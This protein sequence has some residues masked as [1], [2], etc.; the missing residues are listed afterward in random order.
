M[1]KH[2]K[3]SKKHHRKRS[4][5][6]S[7]SILKT[8]K[9]FSAP[10][11]PTI[12]NCFFFSLKRPRSPRRRSTRRRSGRSPS[13]PLSARLAESLVSVLLLSGVVRTAALTLCLSVKLERSYKKSKKH[14]KKAKRR[15]H[16]SVRTLC[17]S[18]SPRCVWSVP[19]LILTTTN[20]PR[21]TLTS[22]RRDESATGSTRGRRR[23]IKR[24]TSLGGSPAPSP[25]WS[26]LKRKQPKRRW[27]C[28]SFFRPRR[29]VNSIRH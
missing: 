24:T 14:K 4:R 28:R 18:L 25:N 22:R 2:S 1:K 7:V 16:K 10:R 12:I 13:L 6:R 9:K 20:R 3:K 15:R 5:S 19:A 23:R 29:V 27:A 11:N 21:P 26:L 8:D 17:P